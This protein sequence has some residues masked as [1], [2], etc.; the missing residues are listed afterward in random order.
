[1]KGSR[2]IKVGLLTLISGVTLYFGLSY[3]KGH[4]VFSH[5]ATYYTHYDN[6]GGL[7]ASNVVQL[8]GVNVGRV[9]EI[10][11]AEGGM[12]RVVVE[13]QVESSLKLGDQ[14]QAILQSDGVLG[15]KRIALSNQQK[16][17][18]LETGDTLRSAVEEGV[19][20][21]IKDQAV[22]VIA[23]TDSIASSLSVILKDLEGT[24]SDI[25]ALFK[26]LNESTKLGTEIMRDNRSNIRGI[27]RRLNQASEDLVSMEQELK[28]L[29]G[30]FNRFADSLNA[31][32]IK[33]TVEDTRQTLAELK[34]T[35]RGLNQGKGTAG[36]LLQDDSLY[37][38][39]NKSVTSLDR[40]LIDMEAR[41]KRYV[42]F[43]LF[44]RKDDK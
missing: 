21:E 44:G 43:S 5:Y 7:K 29:P 6:V 17:G 30:K 8:N 9:Q 26:N 13:L 1:M 10:K 14:S 4:G 27:T 35:L 25:N 12:G 40:L 15:G 19:L 38:N 3:L 33:S 23:K 18:V 20:T 2:E 24:T 31:A 22:P 32:P 16:S 36:K 41:P 11:L 34:T 39:L 37:N 42:H 28:P